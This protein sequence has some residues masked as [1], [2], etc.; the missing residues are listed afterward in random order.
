MSPLFL[1]CDNIEKSELVARGLTMLAKGYSIAE[2][3]GVTNLPREQIRA[4]RRV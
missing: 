1:L 4:L 2:V 3:I